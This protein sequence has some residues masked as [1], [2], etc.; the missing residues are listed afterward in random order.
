MCLDPLASYA[1]RVPKLWSE[2]IDGHRRAVRAAAVE[3]AATLVGERGVAGVTMSAIAATAGIGRAT[4]YKHFP[5]VESVLLAWHE[6]HVE[7][8]LARLAEVRERATEPGDRLAAVLAA[9]A[10]AVRHQQGADIV[11]ILHGGPHVAHAQQRLA[12]FLRTA[13]EEAAQLGRVRTDVPVDELAAYCLH[14]VEAAADLRTAE[15][16]DRLVEVILTGLTPARR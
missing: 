14:A 4:L 6:Q 12:D 7:Q 13:L 15:A 9:Y 16:T 11:A 1:S 2:T 10:Q 5:D 8:H 3:A